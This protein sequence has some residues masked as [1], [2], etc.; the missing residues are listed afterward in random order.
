MLEPFQLRPVPFRT[1]YREISKDCE[2]SGNKSD[3]SDV[4]I[5]DEALPVSGDNKAKRLDNKTFRLMAKMTGQDHPEWTFAD[6]RD[7]QKGKAGD[8]GFSTCLFSYCRI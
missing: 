2:M 3:D 4:E 6:L 1:F 8:K 5:V 7:P